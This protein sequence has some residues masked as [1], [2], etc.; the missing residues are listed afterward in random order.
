MLED[1]ELPE[2]K[3]LIPG[4]IDSTTNY[5]EHPELVSQRLVRSGQLVG[6]EN[7]IAGS[8]CGFCHVRQLPGHRSGDHV[9]QAAGDVRGAQLAS[10]ALW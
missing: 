9:G 10:E 1:V 4:V 6:R 3:V 2:G 8:D 7:V 5:T